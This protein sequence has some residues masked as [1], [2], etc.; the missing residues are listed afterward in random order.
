MNW[1]NL[2][3]RAQRAILVAQEEAHVLN[4]DYLGT[5]HLLLGLVKI[6]EGIAYK[7]ITSMDIDPNEIVKRVE[8]FVKENKQNTGQTSREEVILTPKAKRV[9]ELAE[10]EA[11]N[12]G[13]SYIS[14]EH[15]LLAIIHEGGGV[16]IK[17]LQDFPNSFHFAPA[18]RF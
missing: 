10:R 14:T 18:G 6:E 1:N 12:L 4:N 11:I 3:E 9:L 15:I 13:D 7:A 17:I 5:E 2:T 16:A 8:S